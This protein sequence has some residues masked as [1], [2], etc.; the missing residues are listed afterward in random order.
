MITNT[1]HVSPFFLNLIFILLVSIEK[2][3]GLLIEFLSDLEGKG[4][5]AEDI[6]KV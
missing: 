4:Q 5:L 1:W 2:F 3:L 6:E